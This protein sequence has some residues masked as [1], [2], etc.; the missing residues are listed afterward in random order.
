MYSKNCVGPSSLRENWGPIGHVCGHFFA[1]TFVALWNSVLWSG[2][3]L[4]TQDSMWTGSILLLNLRILR[5]KIL[6][7][8]YPIEKVLLFSIAIAFFHYYY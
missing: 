3:F 2:F 8:P 4:V 1:E 5:R 6:A 7:S